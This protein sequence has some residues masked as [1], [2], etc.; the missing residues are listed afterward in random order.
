M[1]LSTGPVEAMW[2][3][4][5]VATVAGWVAGVAGA[6]DDCVGLVDCEGLLAA[7]GV[8]AVPFEVAAGVLLLLAPAL[9]LG[10]VEAGLLSVFVAFFASSLAACETVSTFAATL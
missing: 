4:P 10:V 8:E 9:L 3:G 6:E 5:V 7:G 2:L 1:T